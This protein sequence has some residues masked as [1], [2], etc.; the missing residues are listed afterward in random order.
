MFLYVPHLAPRFGLTVAAYWLN[1][2]S[3]RRAEGLEEEARYCERRAHDAGGPRPA[4]M[5]AS[6]KTRKACAL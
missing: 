6:G 3:A 5:T 1:C 2:A 4:W